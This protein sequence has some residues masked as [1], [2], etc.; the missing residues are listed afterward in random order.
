MLKIFKCFDFKKSGRVTPKREGSF[1]LEDH[2]NRKIEQVFGKKKSSSITPRIGIILIS[3][4]AKYFKIYCFGLKK[5]N[6]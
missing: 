3:K 1:K 4:Y 6:R 5:S 2:K